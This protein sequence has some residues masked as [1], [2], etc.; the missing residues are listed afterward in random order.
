MSV[1]I[2]A[3]VALAWCF[4]DEATE[5][6]D[7]IALEIARAGAFVPSLFHLEISNVLLQ[8]ERRGRIMMGDV[9]R[10]LE[11]IGKLPLEV[12]HQTASRAT[13][14]I[15]ALARA[16]KLT[17]YDAAYLELAARK[18]CALATKDRQLTAAA[19]H[20]GVPTRG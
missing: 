6:T 19:K 10:R 18:G 17:V 9:T 20:V 4:D 7:E 8:A 15:L 5:E 12:D 13:T 2:D 11:L 14:E 1:V 16:E 3:S